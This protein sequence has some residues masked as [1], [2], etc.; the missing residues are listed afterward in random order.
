[1]GLNRM[2]KPPS[3]TVCINR[4]GVFATM[5][6]GSDSADDDDHY[7]GYDD[8]SDDAE[9]GGQG[10]DVIDL[11]ESSD[12]DDDDEEEEEEEEALH[13][14]SVAC[15]REM[16][17]HVAHAVPVEHRTHAAPALGCERGQGGGRGSSSGSSTSSSGS[18]AEGMVPARGAVVDDSA[19]SGSERSSS[20]SSSSDSGESETSDLWA[21]LTVSQEGASPTPKPMSAGWNIQAAQPTPKSVRKLCA[22]SSDSDSDDSVDSDVGHAPPRCVGVEQPRSL[23][24]FTSPHT[25]G[26]PVWA[27]ASR[28]AVSNFDLSSQ[29]REKAA[30]Q[31]RRDDHGLTSAAGCA[32]TSGR[33]AS[34]DSRR[35]QMQ[36][37]IQRGLPEATYMGHAGLR[38]S[39]PLA[40]RTAQ[41]SFYLLVA[42]MDGAWYPRGS[43]RA[44][45]GGGGLKAAAA[46]PAAPMQYE[47]AERCVCVV[48]RRDVAACW[49]PPYTSRLK[50]RRA[51]RFSPN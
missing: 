41:E 23:I 5:V 35:R 45:G 38:K 34:A 48:P 7:D 26:R 17:M 32:G 20:D 43:F 37:E 15:D 2:T 42:R 25:Q 21:D 9:S 36:Q 6:D 14:R 1:M 50:L 31:Q 49:N 40:L 19:D 16:E 51:H 3:G 30:G 27:V 11:A 39:A 4:S 29:R 22:E 18:D 28:Y 8:L 44:R 10:D 33:A 47:D 12:D 46:V 24:L 13:W